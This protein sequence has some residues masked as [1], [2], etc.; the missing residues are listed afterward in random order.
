MFEQEQLTLAEL[1][2]FVSFNSHSEFALRTVCALYERRN[3]AK[4]C[5]IDSADLSDESLVSPKEKFRRFAIVLR[6]AL[7]SPFGSVRQCALKLLSLMW[8]FDALASGPSCSEND[9]ASP[10]PIMMLFEA[11]QCEISFQSFRQRAQ[12]FRR[13]KRNNLLALLPSDDKSFHEL[14]EKLVI[15]VLLAQ[16]YERLTLYWPLL[17][18]TIESYAQSSD[19]FWDCFGFALDFAWDALSEQKGGNGSEG[20]ETSEAVNFGSFRVQLLRLLNK[21]P[22]A[23][24]ELRTRYLSPKLIT[25][26]RDEFV[27]F[28]VPLQSTSLKFNE[29]DEVVED[30]KMNGEKESPVS[31]IAVKPLRFRIGRRN[32]VQAIKA[33]LAVYGRFSNPKGVFSEREVLDIYYE[34]L[35]VNEAEIQQAAL[36]CL[37]TYKYNWLCPYR[38]HLEALLDPR[39]LRDHLVLFG[40]DNRSHKNKLDEHSLTDQHRAELIPVLLRLLYGSLHT[41]VASR[42]KAKRIAIFRFLANCNSDELSIFLRLL[43]GPIF[44]FFEIDEN[45]A[46]SSLGKALHSLDSKTDIVQSVSLN[47]LKSSLGFLSDVFRFLGPFLSDAQLDLLFAS[48]VL[49]A[50]ILLLRSSLY[51]QQKEQIQMNGD[52]VT[53]SDERFLKSLRKL[54]FL[55]LIKFFRAFQSRPNLPVFSFL[56]LFQ[57]FIGPLIRDHNSGKAF[58]SDECLSLPVSVVRLFCTFAQIKR[59]F[60][61]LNVPLSIEFAPSVRR[62]VVASPMAFLCDQLSKNKNTIKMDI[63]RVFCSMLDS[64]TD[65]AMEGVGSLC[66]SSDLFD[67]LPQTPLTMPDCDETDDIP[68]SFG[69]RL[70]LS[71]GQSDKILSHLTHF[72]NAEGEGKASDQLG[73][74]PTIYFDLLSRLVAFVLR[75]EFA[76]LFARTLLR[77]VAFK[78][79]LML[80]RKPDK[81]VLV[82]GTLERLLPHLDDPLDAIG[83]FASLFSHLEGRQLRWALTQMA[84]SVGKN[85]HLPSAARNLIDLLEAL[86]S[87][88]TRRIEEPDADRRCEALVRLHDWYEHRHRHILLDDG[89]ARTLPLLAHSHVNSMLQKSDISLRG[90]AANTFRQLIHFVSTTANDSNLDA[91]QMLRAHFIPLILRGLRTSVDD[92]STRHEFIQCFAFLV[93]CFPNEPQFAALRHLTDTTPTSTTA[94]AS[95]DFGIDPDVDFFECATHIQLHRRQRAFH[96]LAERLNNKEL[97]IGHSSLVR[98]IVPIVEPYLMDTASNRSAL[99]DQALHLFSSILRRT[100]WPKYC[101]M[102]EH[103]LRLL[104]TAG[105]ES[106]KGAIRVIGAVLNAFHFDLRHLKIKGTHSNE[107]GNCDQKK[108]GNTEED[109]T[110]EVGEGSETPADAQK[111]T[112]DM[113]RDKKEEEKRRILEV[114]RGRLLPR[115]RECLHR[116]NGVKK[117]GNHWDEE[118]QKLLRAPL[119]LSIVKLL[120]WLPPEMSGHHLHGLV[121]FLDHLLMS[122]SPNTR[123]NARK[124][125]EQMVRLLG[126]AKLPF[127]I[128]EVKQSLNKGYQMHVMAVTVHALI[129]AMEGHLANGDIEPI[130]KEVVDVC[131]WE[132]FGG[133][134]KAN[135]AKDGIV[136][137]ELDRRSD[138]YGV[139]EAR[140]NGKKTGHTLSMVGRFVAKVDPLEHCVFAAIRDIANASSRSE[141]MR[142]LADW[143]RALG[144][145]LRTNSAISVREQLRW[146]FRLFDENLRLMKSD[147]SRMSH[148]GGGS[149]VGR[150]P[151]N[152]LLLAPEPKRLGVIQRV[153]LKSKVHIFVEFALQILIDQIAIIR[154]HLIEKSEKLADGGEESEDEHKTEEEGPKNTK[155]V[156]EKSEDRQQIVSLLEQFVPLIIEAL[157][158]K[159]DKIIA[160]SLRTLLSLFKCS[161]IF[162]TSN[163]RT[164]E[165]VDRFFVLLADYSSVGSAGKQSNVTELQQQLFKCLTQVVRNVPPTLLSGARLQLLFNY[166][167]TDIL[168]VHKQTTAFSLLKAIIGRKID[169]KSLSGIVTYLSELAITS[170]SAN[171][172]SQ[173]RQSLL[174]YLTVHPRGQ[175]KYERWM[176]FFLNQCEYELEEGRLSALEM[177]HSIIS[178]FTEEANARYALLVH[179]KLCLRLLN[180]DSIRCRHFVALS[181]RRLFCSVTPSAFSDC[182]AATNDWLAAKK[183]SIRLLAWRAFAQIIASECQHF[184][185]ANLRQI[186]QKACRSFS[187]STES[188]AEQPNALKMALCELLQSVV[189]RTPKELLE[190][191]FHT[192]KTQKT[193]FFI[194]HEQKTAI[195]W[196]QFFVNLDHCLGRCQ[197]N[198][199]HL[200]LSLVA[201]AF[202]SNFIENSEIRVEV[203][204]H[205]SGGESANGQSKLDYSPLCS[206]CFNL[207]A[208][209]DP[210]PPEKNGKR[211]NEEE[212]EGNEENENVQNG[213][214]RWDDTLA[215]QAVRSLAFLM[216]SLS[217]DHFE[218]NCKKLSKLCWAE[219]VKE[220]DNGRKRLSILKLVG[221][222]VVNIPSI[223]SEQFTH[224]CS[225][226]ISI[227]Y[228]EMN[229]KS[230]KFT[231]ELHSLA[232]EVSVVLRKRIGDREFTSKLAKC[233]RERSER[234]S[235]RKSEAK[236]LFVTNPMAAIADK[237]RR[238]ERKKEARRRRVDVLKP[239]RELKR[240][241]RMKTEEWT[242]R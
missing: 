220:P 155:S 55:T 226:F 74:I 201:G 121:L 181:L 238:H 104:D 116:W 94:S 150:R 127:V 3:F 141:T 63:L 138:S 53:P 115:L 5:P 164:A 87:W 162:W 30:D 137:A 148:F 101:Q 37:F 170:P 203:T 191:L 32:A 65:N 189:N 179:L 10:D 69:A 1:L 151:V 105:E 202:L 68:P 86:E 36:G 13:L 76:S 233:Q 227:I 77:F 15:D 17:T 228:R 152:C 149:S 156:S 159:Y 66:C 168:D 128:R 16:F 39:Q 134:A 85:R 188:F 231:E 171:I 41:H 19:S 14:M 192:E 88:D 143:L 195:L 239:Y 198:A 109:Q 235:R 62:S 113:A 112:E 214:G 175:R 131:R 222:L 72:V 240:R 119:T 31:P 50:R 217:G 23:R 229:K 221:A 58:S 93:H 64:E 237:Q 61:L 167:E 9:K 75:P 118:E 28:D 207:I 90:T 47:K 184:G 145:G 24:P 99:S 223:A 182:L 44:T 81:A 204:K 136:A 174:L 169:D 71:N 103:F 197:R 26:Y 56:T 215:E 199:L 106:T 177:V 67:A 21:L 157:K 172:R 83:C 96:K 173:C 130:L 160:L 102:L 196:P 178:E 146:A 11:E 54:L 120:E 186:A 52:D 20:T 125:L 97:S 224:L 218:L 7:R 2:Q 78:N 123:Q 4:I 117:P 213:G 183:P 165:L 111:E 108:E 166:V 132:T 73:R 232:L 70:V 180:D 210:K 29:N 206:L 110:D 33:F 161:Q 154:H 43:F 42:G 100:P 205:L 38:T 158:Q 147:D 18:E 89:A 230:P 59:Y 194:K 12:L 190:D 185:L 45:D 98:F 216:P 144:V 84:L 80:R 234:I 122:R 25:L 82:L 200:P 126:P 6:P 48:I 92:E 60:P 114:V 163:E 139:P 129:G 225:Y 211:E 40:V 49:I 95:V 135:S 22:S 46:L 241:R 57:Q 212:E 219:A 242:K 27:Q 91:V 142:K 187:I 153:A 79:G 193:P 209:I 208:Q 140:A 236:T 124:L 34:L 8:P 176:E 51:S 133:H 107:K 35:L